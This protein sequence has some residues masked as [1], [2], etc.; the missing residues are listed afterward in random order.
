MYEYDEE[1]LNTFLR[2]QSQLF[3]EP[4]AETPEEAEAFL[5]DCMAVVADSLEEVCQFFEEEG[6]DTEGMSPEEIEDAAEVF[7]LSDGRYLI[8]EG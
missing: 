7:A 6:L 1:C 8:V 4:V 2:L 3:D 5:E